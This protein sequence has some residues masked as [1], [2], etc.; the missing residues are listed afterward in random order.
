[1]LLN[2]NCKTLCDV[3]DPEGGWVGIGAVNVAKGNISMMSIDQ[4]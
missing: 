4:E 3:C 1:M 2:Y